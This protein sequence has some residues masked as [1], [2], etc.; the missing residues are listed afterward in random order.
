MNVQVVQVTQELEEL[1]RM[2]NNASKKFLSSKK[3]CKII[4]QMYDEKLA[5]SFES[6][7]IIIQKSFA[8]R[9]EQYVKF[10]STLYE[11]EALKEKINNILKKLRIRDKSWLDLLKRI[12]SEFLT[13]ISE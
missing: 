4:N 10:L 3:A 11:G 9:M 6:F 8:E 5:N 1:I 2:V 12:C 7:E 13:K